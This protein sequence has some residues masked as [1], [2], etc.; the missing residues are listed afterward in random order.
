V[1]CHG[2]VQ[3]YKEPLSEDWISVI[4]AQSGGTKTVQVTREMLILFV[5]IASLLSST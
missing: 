4:S 1:K 2:S 3:E 5:I